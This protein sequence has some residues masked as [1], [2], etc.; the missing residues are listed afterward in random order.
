MR[1]IV[2]ICLSVCFSSWGQTIY[3]TKNIIPYT[4]YNHE[5]QKFTIITDSTG[6]QEYNEETKKWEFRKLVYQ[7]DEPF[8]KFLED[9]IFLHEKGSKVFFIDRGC[10]FVY[11][12]E[13]DTLK[14]HDRSFHHKNQFGGTFFLYKGEPHIF[15]GYGLF[16]MKNIITYYNVKG[17]EWFVHQVTGDAPK[18]RYLAHGIQNGDSFYMVAGCYNKG[19][20]YDDMWVFNFGDLKWK[21][22]GKID[23]SLFNYTLYTTDYRSFGNLSQQ[24][25]SNGVSLF[26]LDYPNKQI[27]KYRMSNEF[28]LKNI[29]SNN[30]LVMYTKVGKHEGSYHVIIENK[31]DFFKHEK[32]VLSLLEKPKNQQQESSKSTWFKGVFIL[33]SLALSVLFLLFVFKRLKKNRLLDLTQ[34]ERELFDFMC[35]KGEEGIEISEVS[36]FV[37]SDNPSIDTLKKRREGL[38]KSLKFKLA[39]DAKISIHEVIIESKHAQDKRVKVLILN[40]KIISHYRKKAK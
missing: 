20:Y 8:N 25:I 35:E 33:L 26:D 37:N 11:I 15:G 1:F 24:Y 16:T 32:E 22:L 18:P 3:N 14:R 17:R 13:N 23:E 30:N 27:T 40:S 31:S 34:S 21:L 4:F 12:L 7:L 36:D 5:R 6:C 9:Y 38:I 19:K 39:Q 28:V 29:L 10:G 2:F